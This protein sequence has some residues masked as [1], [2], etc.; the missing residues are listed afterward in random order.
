MKVI[1]TVL[2][3]IGCFITA[4]ILYGKSRAVYY[5]GPVAP[6]FNGREFV[7]HGGNLIKTRGDL[8]KWRFENNRQ[9]WPKWVDI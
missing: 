8:L 6:N 4:L 1:L 9:I 2:L 7:N 3:I 5:A